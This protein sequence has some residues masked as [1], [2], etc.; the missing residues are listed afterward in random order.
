MTQ[1]T[2]AFLK[3]LYTDLEWKVT[4]VGSAES[5]KH[6]QV[7]DSVLV[8]PV[9]MGVNRFVFEAPAPDHTKIPKQDL[10]GVTVALLSCL[11]RDKEFIRIGYYVNNEYDDPEAA[12]ESKEKAAAEDGMDIDQ[13]DGE[14]EEDDEEIPEDATGDDEEPKEDTE[15]DTKVGNKEN[16][17]ASD[18]QEEEPAPKAVKAETIPETTPAPPVEV[19]LP[20]NFDIKKIK[21]SILEDK[22]RVT[23]FAIDWDENPGANKPEGAT[24]AE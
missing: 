2:I 10:L 22:P 4:Y 8:G 7:L 17:A 20:A 5:E 3:V 23:R 6:D 15:T 9:P 12:V 11:Y 16:S 18:Q 24:E 13:S 1:Y 19:S 21:R 14:E